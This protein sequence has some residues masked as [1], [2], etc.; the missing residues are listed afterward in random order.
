M[1]F[2]SCF[3]MNR[4]RLYFSGQ[5]TSLVCPPQ[6][7][8]CAGPQCPPPL[9][10]GGNSDFAGQVLVN[11][12]TIYLL[13]FH[14][15]KWGRHFR[16]MQ[17]S[18]SSSDFPLRFCSRWLFLPK[19]YLLWCLQKNG[20]PTLALPPHL[21][22]GTQH[23]TISK[24]PPFSPYIYLITYV[25]S[26]GTHGFQI[27]PDLAG[28]RISSSFWLRDEYCLMHIVAFLSFQILLLSFKNLEVYFGRQLGYCKSAWLFQGLFFNIVGASLI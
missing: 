8:A 23:S 9:T 27:F 16:T 6:H 12:F 15:V 22:V 3:P 11:F 17:V 19:Q 5:N 28:G 1:G 10:G 18:Y 2:F 4:F 26:V 13:F 7:M 20:Y 24:N 14:F 25:F 21:W